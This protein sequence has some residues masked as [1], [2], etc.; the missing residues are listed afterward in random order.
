MYKMVVSDF[1]NA[2][3]DQEEAI[4]LSTMIEIDKIRRRGILFCISTS[5]SARVVIDYN[6]DFPFIDYVIAFNGSYVYDVTSNI[7]LYN[8]NL[9]V[10][11]IKK[12]YKMF[13]DDNI[14]FYTLDYCNYIGKYKDKDYSKKIDDFSLFI[15]ENKKNI[16]SVKICVNTM[17]EAIKIKESIKSLDFKVSIYI[18]ESENKFFVGVYSGMSDKFNSLQKLC[19]LKKIDLSQVV[20]IGVSEDSYQI[21]KNVGNSYC[22]SNASE[23]LKNISKN[24]GFDNN[25]KGVE[26]VIK[27]I[28]FTV[29]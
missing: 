8:K 10:S 12:L 9:S 5:K 4:P 25:E 24:I 11:V 27:Q 16:Y 17:K 14:C 18:K 20:A 22:L 1:Y 13:R 19:K 26:Q 6:K 2:L 3:I 21:V 29:E 23:K 28:N 15:E 7:V